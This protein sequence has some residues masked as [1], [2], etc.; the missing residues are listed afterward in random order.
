MRLDFA[1]AIPAEAET[2]G[3]SSDT[4][5]APN[6]VKKMARNMTTLEKTQ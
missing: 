2:C 4:V 5:D 6:S 3:D 1:E